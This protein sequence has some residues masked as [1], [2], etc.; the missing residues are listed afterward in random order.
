[1]D[2]RSDAGGGC[3]A[4][5]CDG[6]AT[7]RRG[8]EHG[9]LTCRSVITPGARESGSAAPDTRQRRCL[10]MTESGADDTEKTA[11]FSQ[12]TVQA[13]DTGPQGAPQGPPPSAPQGPQPN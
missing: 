2:A 4:R 5:G 11:T 3:G 8:A 13:G 7:R 12:P 1:R 9:A 10:A 6:R